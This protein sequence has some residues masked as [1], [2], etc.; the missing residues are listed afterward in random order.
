MT[1]KLKEYFPMIRTRKEIL[2]E[3]HPKQDQK[4]Q[5]RFLNPGG[6]TNGFFQDS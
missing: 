6:K 2:P 4:L 5:L 1:N 3:V